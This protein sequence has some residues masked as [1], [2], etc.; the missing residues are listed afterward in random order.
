MSIDQYSHRAESINR[1]IQEINNTEELILEDITLATDPNNLFLS[2]P[3]EVTRLILDYLPPK[4][5]SSINITCKYLNTLVEKD[6]EK[7]AKEKLGDDVATILK[8]NRNSW[9]RLVYD[10]ESTFKPESK[11]LEEGYFSEDV[12]TESD[13]EAT[14]QLIESLQTY[15][16]QPDEDMLKNELEKLK[17]RNLLPHL[18]NIPSDSGAILCSAAKNGLI[19]N[20]ELLIE[21]GARDFVRANEYTDK[22]ALGAGALYYAALHSQVE[23]V[24]FLLK[25]GA[26][27]NLR[28]L[29]KGSVFTYFIIA[30]LIKNK[31]FEDDN[32]IECLFWILKAYLN[33]NQEKKYILRGLEFYLLSA[34]QKRFSRCAYLLYAMGARINSN[35]YFDFNFESE[36][37]YWND[38]VAMF[39][40]FHERRIVDFKNKRGPNGE[41][42]LH[43][44]LSHGAEN[45]LEY[46]I[47][48]GVPK[49]IKNVNGE[50]YEVSGEN[51]LR[52]KINYEIWSLMIGCHT[53]FKTAFENPNRLYSLH[54]KYQLDLNNHANETH[55]HLAAKSNK[56]VECGGIG[57]LELLNC[58]VNPKIKNFDGKTALDVAEAYFETNGWHHEDATITEQRKEFALRNIEFLKKAINGT[59][60]PFETL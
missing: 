12:G 59:F 55:L 38:D 5:L 34:I 21:Y 36:K 33:S 18:L 40:F 43:T 16:S 19:K 25:K 4:D 39:K 41:S 45:T 47:E 51:A 56:L 53:A 42:V 46:F 57:I 13:E 58:G 10:L 60:V 26:R 22:D 52:G 24:K 35:Y 14:K 49:D 48:I 44:A 7:K 20:A 2:Q 54:K 37:Y 6:F 27:A 15:A 8:K 17:E 1:S 30:E 9:R 31:Q 3:Q 50:T 23:T 32:F 28:F 11:E 29:N